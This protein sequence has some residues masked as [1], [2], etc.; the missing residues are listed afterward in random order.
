MRRIAALIALAALAACK[1]APEAP[2]A[3]EPKPL[4]WTGTAIVHTNTGPVEIGVETK[5]T[6]FREARSDTW[7]LTEGPERRRSLVVGEKG[8]WLEVNGERTEMPEPMWR[9]EKQQFAIY[10]LMQ[11]AIPLSATRAGESVT[12]GGSAPDIPSTTFR[13]DRGGRLIGARNVVID[14]GGSPKPVN[15]RFRFSGRIDVAGMVWPRRIEISQREQPYFTLQIKTI[16][17]G[18]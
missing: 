18:R 12:L 3:V 6:P 9:H 13:F 10:A 15:Q 8:G 14:P 17:V 4:S 11:Q 16:T 2:K 7:L 5:M 1:P